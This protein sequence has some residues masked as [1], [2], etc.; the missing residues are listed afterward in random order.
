MSR[1]IDENRLDGRPFGA[2]AKLLHGRR[3]T[4]QPELYRLIA[5]H[6]RCRVVE[7]DA[8]QHISKTT[9]LDRQYIITFVNNV[10]VC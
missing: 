8:V 7:L 9:V 10:T 2:G 4:I 1:N 5:K 3:R 6:R